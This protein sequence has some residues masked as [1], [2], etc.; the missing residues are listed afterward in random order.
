MRRS[1]RIRK[2]IRA[3]ARRLNRRYDAHPSELPDE[4]TSSGKRLAPPPILAALRRIPTQL[5]RAN[6]PVDR[7]FAM[8]ASHF[9]GDGALPTLRELASRKLL[10]ALK[11]RGE[12]PRE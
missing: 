11:R 7:Y 8:S 12:L 6:A 1:A 3:A 4:V 10:A 2:T 5:R 9:E